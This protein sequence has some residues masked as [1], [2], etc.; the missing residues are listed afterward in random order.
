MILGIQR[1]VSI[2]QAG[3]RDVTAPFFSHAWEQRK[4]GDFLVESHIPGSNGATARK[5]TVKLWGKGV[6][7]KQEI[8]SGSKA[9]SYYVR[10]AGQFMYGKLDFL[11][12]A[13]GIVPDELD[14]YESTQ[15]SPAF[16]V[17][18]DLN[19]FFF[20]EYISR[21]SFYVYQGT[22]ANG[23]RKA[24]RIHADTF[25]AMPI[26]LPRKN[27]QDCIAQL[28]AM[29]DDLITLHQRKQLNI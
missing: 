28:F 9:T 10:R 11:H 20:V 15:D 7:A 8:Y 4:V 19:P 22:I 27:E 1:S 24:K 29:F 5:L 21:K 25:F 3:L 26:V 2:D 18:H 16:D 23:S 6:V 13:F 17:A 12:Q 14:G